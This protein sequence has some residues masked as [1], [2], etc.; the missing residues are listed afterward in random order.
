[1][2]TSSMPLTTVLAPVPSRCRLDDEP[3]SFPT[4]CPSQAQH[5][6][7]NPRRPKRRRVT[8][9]RWREKKKE[10]VANT[11]PRDLQDGRL[12]TLL[13]TQPS[14][15]PETLPSPNPFLL[16]PFHR[17][18]HGPF[19]PPSPFPCPRS[20]RL[21]RRSPISSFSCSP[22][23]LFRHDYQADHRDKTSYML[24]NHVGLQNYTPCNATRPAASDLSTFR[25]WLA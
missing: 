4:T 6:A 1:M 12:Q 16:V 5:A 7:Q 9:T 20:P 18:F 19:F 3:F 22:P 21:P 24:Y 11:I 8:D 25:P 10:T 23:L 2:T 17:T 14:H 13:V 15:L